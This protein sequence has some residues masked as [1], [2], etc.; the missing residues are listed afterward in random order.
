MGQTTIVLMILTVISKIFGFVRES[1]MAAYIG[2]GDLK[3]IYTTA[4]TIPNVLMWVVATGIRS[5]YI[6]IYN[7]VERE[8]GE[9]EANKFTSNIINILMLYGLVATVIIFLF[10]TPISK[11]FSP[12]L[13][14]QQLTTA[15]NFTR[16]IILSTFALLYSS[17]IRGFLNIKG[18]FID[19]VITVFILNI[20]TIFA[21]MLTAKFE[22]PYILIY[23]ALLANIFQYIRYPFISKKLGFKYSR[24]F[25]IKDKYVKRLLL[26]ILPIMVSSATDQ[27]SILIDNSMASAFFGVSSVSKIFYAKT[28]LN[29]IMGVITLSISTVTFPDIAK[30]GQE[31]EIKIMKS[32]I[33]SAIILTMILVI[34]A[35]L[36]MMALARPI[37]QLAFERNAF[38]GN[39]TNIVSSLIVS[40]A[41]YI[42][43]ASVIKILSN[44]FYSVGDSKTPVVIVLFQQFI[45]VILN[46]VLI[47]F[48]DL[49][50]IAYSTT[51]S[52]AIGSLVLIIAFY[53]EFG[54]NEDN[55]DILSLIK[56]LS[57]SILMILIIKFTYKL[58][59]ISLIFDLIITVLISGVA[60]LILIKLMKIDEVELLIINIKDNIHKIGNKNY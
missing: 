44:G 41:P 33:N 32:K 16:I 23:G 59:N 19:P 20:I 57:S 17:V 55:R 24:T 51:I 35:T 48:F 39:D 38:T 12:K 15:A 1:V 54:K 47:K 40:Y 4:M 42:I 60:Y 7:K 13:N 10:A 53:K 8:K 6:P 49:N 28:M 26:L 36:G 31:G 2:A 30:A 56:I 11:L 34:P 3:S 5:G 46:F 9:V 29:F 58:L 18:N 37:I 25:N 52:T 27:I 21:T 45:N 50:G 22:N 43:F 14:G